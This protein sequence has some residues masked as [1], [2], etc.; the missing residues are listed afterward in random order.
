MGVNGNF[1]II[2]GDY[3]AH[4]HKGMGFLFSAPKDFRLTT[5]A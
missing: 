1:E 4:I 5:D 2:L 3:K